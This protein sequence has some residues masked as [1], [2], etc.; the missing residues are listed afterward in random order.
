MTI[1]S[2]ADLVIV[3]AGIIGVAVARDYLGRYPGKKVVLV[4]KAPHP[5]AHQTGRNS[6]VIHAGVYY[7]PE[8][9]K[10][11]FC[12]QGLD[13]TLAYCRQHDLPYEQCGKIIVAT[14]S[15]EA[16]RLETLYANCQQNDLQPERWSAQMLSREEPAIRGSEGVFVRHTGIT[17]YAVITRHMLANCQ[18]NRNFSLITGTE[19]TAIEEQSDGVRLS[20]VREHQPTSMLCDNL[21][22][23]AGVMSDELIRAQGL[24]CDFSILPFKGEY[25]RLSSRFDDVTA[26]LIYP[27]P[28]PAMPFLGVH[29]TRMIGGYTTVGPNAVL[30]SGREAYERISVSPKEWYRLLR[31]SGL[32]PLLWRFRKAV[33]SELITSISKQAYARRIQKYCPSVTANDFAPYRSGIRAQAVRHDGTLMQDFHFVRSERVLHV[34]N[35]PSPAATSAMPIARTVVDKL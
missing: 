9:L 2:H 23:C 24:P 16:E 5:A 21:V 27:V 10:A 25:F 8:S 4:E 3:G 18:K 1:P 29:L 17:D 13:A 14:D 35:A 12:R 31:F 30:A 32:Y 6:G 20:L 11:T 22:C 19:V 28:D 7:P 34:A 26:R 15:Q 33:V